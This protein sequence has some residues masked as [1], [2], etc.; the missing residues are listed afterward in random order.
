MFLII[1]GRCFQHRDVARA[2]A[3]HGSIVRSRTKE[4]DEASVR[5]EVPVEKVQDFLESWRDSGNVM[6]DPAWKDAIAF[7]TGRSFES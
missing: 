4:G 5:E 6:H 1:L 7:H 3:N 2:Q